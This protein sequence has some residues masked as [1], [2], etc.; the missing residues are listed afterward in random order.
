MFLEIAEI[1]VK[2]GSNA[3]FE[4]AVAEA[5]PVFLRAQGC[6][7]VELHQTVEEPQRYR[8][9]VQWQRVEDHMETFRNSED[10]QE[11]RR[12]ASPHFAA[13]P[14]VV[15]TRSVVSRSAATDVD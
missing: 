10:F 1:N 7:G 9:I 12:L 14:R 15:H 11:W 3:A 6:L 2:P 5:V 8:L 13:P 4:A